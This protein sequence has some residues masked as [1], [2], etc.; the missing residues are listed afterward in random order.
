M[1][2]YYH[3]HDDT[4]VGPLGSVETRQ[5]KHSPVQIKIMVGKQEAIAG[6]TTSATDKSRHTSQS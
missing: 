1:R 6:A 5:V 3:T 2:G 4:I